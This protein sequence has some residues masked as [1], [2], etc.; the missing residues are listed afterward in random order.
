MALTQNDPVIQAY[1]NARQTIGRLSSSAQQVPY[2]ATRVNADGSSA[3]MA[4]NPAP[5]QPATQTNGTGGQVSATGEYVGG[6]GQEFSAPGITDPYF[7]TIQAGYQNQWD[8]LN[9][10]AS[11]DRFK[12]Q[13]QL[14]FYLPEI[15]YQGGLQRRN[16][17]ADAE[18]RGILRS[19]EAQR[20]VAEQQHAEQ[21]ATSQATMAAQQQQQSIEQQLANQQAQIRREYANQLQSA[22]SNQYLQ[23]QQQAAQQEIAARSSGT[24][25][26]S[27]SAGTIQFTTNGKPAAGGLYVD[28]QGNYFTFNAG[29]PVNIGWDQVNALGGAGAAANVGSNSAYYRK[30]AGLG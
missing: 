10:N 27:S 7:K 17:L 5:A 3:P 30:A 4:S 2:T 20:G 18:G 23:Q 16:V 6:A 9:Q 29:V 13:Q 12:T 1:S 22:A 21:Q 28:D 25:A 24:P 19:G 8:T 14:D 26:S 11:N 15:A